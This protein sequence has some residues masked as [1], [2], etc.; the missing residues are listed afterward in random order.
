VGAA[1]WRVR[2]SATFGELRRHGRRGRSGPLSVT[3]LPGPA[4]QPPRLAF[5]IGRPVGTAV[6]RNRLRRRLRCLFTEHAFALVPGTYL[7][8]AAPAAAHLDYGDLRRTL[9]TALNELP[10][11]E[12]R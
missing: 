5:A 10:G 3:W 8:G 11:A 1:V 6:V 4:D 7:I 2:D 9:S 12:P